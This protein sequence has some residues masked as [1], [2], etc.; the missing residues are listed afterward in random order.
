MVP[1]PCRLVRPW[2]PRHTT[3]LAT[4]PCHVRFLSSARKK[5]RDPTEVEPSKVT[6][7]AAGSKTWHCR[8]TAGR[9]PLGRPD[10]ATVEK[11]PTSSRVPCIASF[12]HLR[13]A[14]RTNAPYPPS[15]LPTDHCWTLAA[16]V[17]CPW[18]NQVRLCTR[19]LD[20]SSATRR[21]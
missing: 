1:L 19:L 9:R 6:S 14:P 4:V 18:P 12:S 15:H 21:G 16:M 10:T 8:P 2:G 17:S 3:L 13:L 20:A 5:K 7:V 11:G